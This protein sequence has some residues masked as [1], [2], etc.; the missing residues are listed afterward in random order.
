MINAEFGREYHDSIPEIAIGR[1]LEL[2]DARTDPQTRFN[3]W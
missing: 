2:L 3:W 1:R